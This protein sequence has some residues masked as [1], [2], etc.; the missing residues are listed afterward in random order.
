MILILDITENLLNYLGEG[1]FSDELFVDILLEFYDK[2]LEIPGDY[3]QLI[4]EIILVNNAGINLGSFNT[5]RINQPDFTEDLFK[6]FNNL[7]NIFNEIEPVDTKPIN[8]FEVNEPAFKNIFNF[9]K[10]ITP[11][12]YDKFLN[13]INKKSNKNE[14]LYKLF[15][16]ALVKNI[17]SMQDLTD[18]CILMI[19]ELE[20]SKFI[21][22]DNLFSNFSSYFLLLL[23]VHNENVKGYR[24]IQS[25]SDTRWEE[26]K[27]PWFYLLI[28]IALWLNFYGKKGINK[29]ANALLDLSLDIYYESSILKSIESSLQ[30]KGITKHAFLFVNE[31]KDYENFIRMLNKTFGYFHVHDCS[32]EGI[33]WPKK[34]KHLIIKNI[35]FFNEEKGRN[36]I[37]NEICKDRYIDTLIILIVD[38]KFDFEDFPRIKYWDSLE[39]DLNNRASEI[40]IKMLNEYTKYINNKADEYKYVISQLKENENEEKNYLRNLD[41]VTKYSVIFFPDIINF[42][43]DLVPANSPDIKELEKFNRELHNLFRKKNKDYIIF[44]IYWNS[45][46]K[47]YYI[48][49]IQD[50]NYF[51]DIPVSSASKPIKYIIYLYKYYSD[52][53]LINYKDLFKLVANWGRK[54]QV[55]KKLDTV[56]RAIRTLCNKNRL[57]EKIHE[58]V[59]INETGCYFRKS[60]EF[61]IKSDDFEIP[62]PIN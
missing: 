42:W 30:A 29:M 35:N 43:Y 49:I 33:N 59:V 6:R 5:I 52:G 18:F 25:N 51:K 3:L 34:E 46:E 1:P 19:Y 13:T 47:N 16:K 57:L 48:K 53:D 10:E 45:S 9:I 32:T 24:Q 27:E 22:F 17:I 54:T 58:C 31:D 36:Q 23:S 2:M 55:P 44:E 15:E 61:E 60:L 37:L 11:E 21:Y 62:G 41:L 12:I 4:E 39:S 7:L 56:K 26:I 20:N 40:F 28:S 50:D 38:K 8:S 14:Y